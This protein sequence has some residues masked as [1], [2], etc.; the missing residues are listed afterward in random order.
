[1]IYMEDKINKLQLFYLQQEEAYKKLFK[2]FHYDRALEDPLLTDEYIPKVLKGEFQEYLGKRNSSGRYKYAMYTI[3][4]REG[5]T[6]QKAMKQFL[7]YTKK[8]WIKNSISCFEWRGMD[9][10][11]HIHSRVEFQPEK[12]VYE[13]K[14]EVYNTFKS[15][16]GNKKHVNVRYSNRDNSFLKYIAGGR[17]I[18]GN[19]VR[20]EC[21]EVTIKMRSKHQLQDI[22]SVAAAVGRREV[23]AP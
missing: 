13:G 22:Y 20:K 7:K 16:V 14:R 5:Q 4:F 15:M 2:Q 6:V 17:V 12:N 3:N 11:M 23:V 9:R 10:G 21:N 19:L 1:M 8:K 18:K